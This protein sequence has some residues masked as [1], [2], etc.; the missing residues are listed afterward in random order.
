MNI[1]WF[2][3]S[4]LIAI[5]AMGILV[6]GTSA[7]TKD[8]VKTKGEKGGGEQ[9]QRTPRST[10]DQQSN[11]VSNF[12]FTV[13]NYG[14]FGLD[15]AASR[16]AGIWP[17][18]SQN[19]YLFGAG[20]WFAALKRPKGST[21][22]R[23]RVIVGY[24]PNSGDSWMVPGSIDDGFE[25]QNT[26]EGLYKN[27]LYFSTDFN[28]ASGQPYESNAALTN[29][30]LW[31]AVP[32]DTL[33]FNNYYGSYIN[34]ITL[35]EK[36]IYQKGPAFIS[37]E[38][39]F[40]VYKDTDL[41]RYEGGAARR[42]AEGYP[43]GFQVEQ[44]MYSWGFGDY[45]D[46]VFVKYLFIHPQQFQDTLFQ[47]WMASVIDV[48]IALTTNS[49]LGADN[50]RARYFEEEPELNLAIQWTNGNRGESGRGFGYL[51]FNFLE[52]PAV[53]ADGFI[54]KD[55]RQ[56]AVSEQLGLQTMR[57]WPITFDPI[58]NE[59][60]YNFMSSRDKD[61][62][63]GAGDRRLMMATGPFNVKPGDSARIVVGIVLASTALGGD[64]TGE[65]ADMAELTRKVRFAQ[66]VYDNNFRAPTPPDPSDIKGMPSPDLAVQIPAVGFMPLNNAVIIQWDSTAE[67][68]V[69][70]L[71]RGMDF[72]G[73]RI[74][75]SRRPDLDTYDLDEIATK[76]RSPLA[77]KQIGT[78]A[79]PSPWVKS[80]N[81]AGSSGVRIDEFELADPIKPGQRRFL[82][83]R[84][85]ST[86]G[87]W[88]KYFTE[89]INSRPAS[90][91]VQSKADSMLDVTRFDT[92]DKS[93]F[94]YLTTQFEDLP[95]VRRGSAAAGTFG[96]NFLL[97][98]VEAKAAKDSLIKLIQARRVKMEP[99]LFADTVQFDSAGTKIVK[100]V[101]RPWEE[102]SAIRHGV[103]SPYMRSL[104]G[105]KFLG[106]R[107]FFDDGDD[108]GDGR[109]NYTANPLQS[110]K[111]INNV[112]YYYAVRAFDEG[113]YLLPTPQ[114]LNGKAVGLPNV[115]N[116]RPAAAR[117]GDAP[118][119]SL[120]V[121]DEMRDR[122]GGIYNI[123]LLIKE[124]QK[125]NQMFAGRNLELEFYR[126]WSRT[127][128]DQNQ[129]T[130]DDQIGLYGVTM[131]LRDKDSRQTIGAW[132][133]LLPPEL[134]PSVNVF[135]TRGGAPGYFTENSST[136]V[137]TNQVRIDT[138]YTNPITI[139]TVDFGLPDNTDK[140]LRYGTYTSDAAC[141]GPS[142][143]AL[144][145]VGLAFDYAIE[146]WG[147][148]Y[149]KQ[150]NGE[151]T[152][153]PTDVYVGASRAKAET[154]SASEENLP[155][156]YF[157]LPFEGFQALWDASHN[158]GPGVY[159]L[160]FT[161]GGT[162]TIVTSF[163]M[164][165]AAGDAPGKSPIVR[166]ENVPYLNV[167]L[168]NLNEYKRVED[169][170][171]VPTDV[172]VSYAKVPYRHVTQPAPT[173]AE[174]E[175]FPKATQVPLDGFT[176]AAYGWRN[177][178]N[179]DNSAQ[180]RANF[181]ADSN[182]GRPLGQG[183]YYLSRALS[184]TGKDTL[185]FCHVISVGGAE[186]MIDYSWRAR[187][188]NRSSSLLPPSVTVP[189]A[190]PR[191]DFKAGDK[192]VFRTFGG[193]LGFP[194][195]NAKVDIKVEQYD[196]GVAGGGYSEE[197]LDQVQVAPNP[198]YVTHEG[199]RSPFEG[200]LYFTRLP[201]Q[202]TINIYTS[203]GSLVQTIK[204]NELTSE[205][206]SKTSVEVWD[207][208]SR[209]R[210]RV[211]SQMLVAEIIDDVTGN[212]VMRKFTIVVGPARIISGQ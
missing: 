106:A 172:T 21:E 23:K 135:T 8:P 96:G 158:N 77:W 145:V 118:S 94:V 121:S 149:R 88:G 188:S 142:G 38:D 162:E 16:G 201:R 125:F 52:S 169:I 73:Y 134:C 43:L 111:L 206:P 151:V 87:P 5:V 154:Y 78:L 11:I 90:Y 62:D 105:G 159:E 190:L 13:T 119:V 65:L 19:Q 48:D 178:R 153:G 55:K 34:D 124:P 167:K 26:S 40:C 202:A 33:R 66:F 75:R 12:A 140:I 117:A 173:P 30:P 157:E 212:K 59:E 128:G 61:G 72:L 42:S 25:L 10:F 138:I 92:F 47:C 155:P 195:D 198:Y 156:A 177:T 150:Q 114:K 211:A 60:R 53:D 122:L 103:F 6:M 176:M 76:R 189:D 100:N 197:Q 126:E 101:L 174:A 113:D 104:R 80:V 45:A 37:E 35:R 46:M 79:L 99:L 15:V 120:S 115:I 98:T 152:G 193:A 20:A 187:R 200:R 14:I 91:R 139:D 3:R 161:E 2:H 204:H 71:E 181:A 1:R 86:A 109:I 97:D 184:T 207:L 68:S 107:T 137:D 179:G 192:I 56:F 85:P 18:G 110:E 69:D 147:G 51:G 148:E 175:Q 141:F 116:V 168:R 180:R 163:R 132:T 171:G 28:S 27:R 183:R 131:F 7:R 39:I 102:T 29:W 95:R 93:R 170:N 83:A 41:E 166:F 58:E 160:E 4:A 81:V 82:V 182:N 112:D 144:G 89:L 127:D 143:Y 133:S 165:E 44:T 31:D 57:N 196:P 194:F 191:A 9:V 36:G 70:T 24:N 130:T 63:Q 199:M 123:R 205:S 54:R 164:A 32:N 203:S 146:Q 136:W 210:Q 185:D 129:Q 186:F 50:D 108:N 67:L 208:L 22:L 74:Y 84:S 17:R 64:A 209:N 49:Q